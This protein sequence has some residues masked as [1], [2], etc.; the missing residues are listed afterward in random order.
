MLDQARK[1]G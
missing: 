1:T